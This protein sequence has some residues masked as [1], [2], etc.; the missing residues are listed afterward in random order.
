MMVRTLFIILI[1]CIGIVS[2]KSPEARRP[3][4][5][6]S[7]SF[8]KESAERNK[9][10]YEEEKAI[11]QKFMDATSENSYITSES[12]FWYFYNTKLDS[13]STQTPQFGDEI[14]FTY[15][16][17]HLDGNLILSE[18]ENGLQNYKID[19]TY[20]DLISGLRDGLKLMKEGETVTFLFPSYKAYGY[21][22]IENKLGTNIPVQS[23]VTLKSI[24]QTQEN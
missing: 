13:T 16:V 8:I 22:G 1:C 12:G 7:G 6:S 9:K 10:I 23:K 20:Q 14:T 4:Q 17:K 24:K 2:C 19:Q 21:Y 5:A 3:I 11:I 18:E 15:D